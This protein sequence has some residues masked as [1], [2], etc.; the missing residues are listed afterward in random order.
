MAHTQVV[1]S[2]AAFLLLAVRSDG[3]LR[4][5]KTNGESQGKRLCSAKDVINQFAWDGMYSS[6]K[7]CTSDLNYNV[8]SCPLEDGKGQHEIY[9]LVVKN[10]A[11]DGSTLYPEFNAVTWASDSTGIGHWLDDVCTNATSLVDAVCMIL[12]DTVGLDENKTNAVAAFDFDQLPDATYKIVRPTWM[13]LFQDGVIPHTYDYVFYKFKDK[14]SDFNKFKESCVPDQS[15]FL[16]LEKNGPSQGEPGLDA[17][18]RIVGDYGAQMREVGCTPEEDYGAWSGSCRCQSISECDAVVQK[19]CGTN[20]SVC[21]PSPYLCPSDGTSPVGY[22]RAYLEYFL[23]ALPGFRGTGFGE[24]SDGETVGT[25]GEP[26]YIVSP[27]IPKT[28]KGVQIT[29]QVQCPA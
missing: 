8:T 14:F 11:K 25:D 27:N 23:D 16:A 4:G 13:N 5:T 24:G 10:E 28:E 18:K 9:G 1:L 7:L 12:P 2:I 22:V 3:A 19:F 26:E 15:V 17:Y 29:E 21:D 20:S 6:S